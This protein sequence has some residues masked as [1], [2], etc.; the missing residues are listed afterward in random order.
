VEL[1]IVN[2]SYTWINSFDSPETTDQIAK[3]LRADTLYEGLGGFTFQYSYTNEEIDERKRDFETLFQSHDGRI[4]YSRLLSGGK[5]GAVLGYRIRYNT[6]EF[7]GTG[8][9]TVPLIRAAGLFS[10][11]DTPADGPALQS[12]P[13]LI[14]GNLSASTGIN[15]GL[16]GDRTTLTNMGLDF[17]FP[18][19]MD[20]LFLWVDRSLPAA[21]SDSFSWEIY[22]SPDNTDASTWTLHATVFPAPFGTFQ[23]RFEISFPPVTTRFIKVV[24]RPLSPAVI[25]SAGFQDIFVTELEGFIT[26]SGETDRITQTEQTN[27]C[28]LRWRPRD[29]TTFGYNFFYRLRETD[30]STER[31]SLLTNSI[32]ANHIFNRVFSGSLRLLR[33]D[34]KEEGEDREAYTF[35]AALRGDYLET[36][37][38]TLTYR[39][40][41]TSTEGSKDRENSLFL[42]NRAD[43]YKGWSA[44]LDTGY[45]W[46]R[47]PEGRRENS[48]FMRVGTDMIPNEVITLNLIYS[49]NLL[50]RTQEGVESS[51]TNQLFDVDLLIV[52]LRT[53]SL[54]A[55]LTFI[56]EFGSS[57]SFQS[58]SANWSPF[59]DGTLQFFFNYIEELRSA[60]DLETR[61]RSINP[62]LR[63]DVTRNAFLET[64]YTISEL[65]TLLEKRDTESVRVNLLIRL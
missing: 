14:D 21:V 19:K 31:D 62:G 28:D 53:L 25:G 30:P 32:S 17:G 27:T 24:T 57:R 46:N 11:D 40:D 48:L 39:S 26:V 63:W 37:R 15:I 23:N 7:S 20:T 42:R 22:V 29:D 60:E 1:P 56:D 13:S 41:Y 43:L 12:L 45:N 52:P 5:L 18:T 6:N 58:Y 2:F 36:F 49:V 33:E 61:E 65:D 4:Y 16:N 10:I 9:G 54:F 59:P 51:A 8:S 55:G 35:N 3:T 44:F 34:R 38:Q 50:E 64:S 47:F